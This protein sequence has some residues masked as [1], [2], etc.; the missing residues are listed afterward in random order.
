MQALQ[1]LVA[2]TL[3]LLCAAGRAVAEVPI[4][5]FILICKR[6]D[7]QVDQCIK[8]S[9]EQLRPHLVRGIPAFN[10]P[11][12][13]PLILPEIRVGESTGIRIRAR[14]VK[15]FGCSDFK[16]NRLR[17]DLARND[18]EMAITLPKLFIL[19][20]Y[21]VDGRVFLLPVRGAGQ[22]TGNM[23][24][25]KGDVHLRGTVSKRDGVD[26]LKYDTLAVRIAV[27]RGSLHLDNLFGGQQTLGDIVNAAIN[28]NFKAFFGELKP[29]VER[30]LSQEFL[31]VA[32]KIVTAVPYEKLFPA[33]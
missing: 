26:Y 9:V 33:S 22:L 3:A 16:I 12:L 30:A 6:T 21:T 15:A 23:T 32:N 10:V 8:K 24:D 17:V 7:P 31:S 11:S 5:D 14:N 4:P 13:E 28:S 2:L 29:S 19:G 1:A 18:I 27:G 25:C 20:D